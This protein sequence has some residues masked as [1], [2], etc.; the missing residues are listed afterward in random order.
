MRKTCERELRTQRR[1]RVHTLHLLQDV[2]FLAHGDVIVTSVPPGALAD[3][4]PGF[5]EWGTSWGTGVR[6]RREE[7]R[8]KP[9]RGDRKR[10]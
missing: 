2:R 7:T 8:E 4:D 10:E 5:D 9:I 1:M 6:Q 3:P